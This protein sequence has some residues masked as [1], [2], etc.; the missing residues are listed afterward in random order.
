LSG[1]VFIFLGREK[2]FPREENKITMALAAQNR[3][4]FVDAPFRIHD[5][6]G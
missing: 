2:I 4:F 6:S 3:E 5:V 1:S